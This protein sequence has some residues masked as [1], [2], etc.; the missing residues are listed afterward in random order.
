MRPE[1]LFYW[2]CFFFCHFYFISHLFLKSNKKK[3]SLF[4]NTKQKSYSL[5]WV[6][7]FQSLYCRV[8]KTWTQKVRRSN[9]TCSRVKDLC[10]QPS[11][12][13][14]LLKLNA[15]NY[16]QIYNMHMQISSLNDD[17][18]FNTAAVIMLICQWSKRHRLLNFAKHIGL[19]DAVNPRGVSNL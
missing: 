6:L 4:C 5:K 9:F 7:L 8:F 11:G 17:L 19:I 16:T 2:I 15:W 1:S 18:A 10:V 12:T 14:V 13:L 3:N